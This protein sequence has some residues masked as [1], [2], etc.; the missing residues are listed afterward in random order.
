M[1]FKE[2]LTK[3]ESLLE[4]IS[5]ATNTLLTAPSLDHALTQAMVFLGQATQV[6]RIYVFQNGQIPLTGEPTMSQRWEWVNLGVQSEFDNSE[7][8]NLPYG[9]ELYR[10]YQEM[11]EGKIIFGLIKDFPEA[12]KSILEPQGILSILVVP[13]LIKQR[14]WGFVGFDNCHESHQWTHTEITTLWA[15]AGCFGGA[16]ARAEAESNLQELNQAL[17]LR[18]EERTRELQQATAAANKANHAKSEF[19]ANMSHEL[20]TPLN[21]ILGYAQ[22]LERSKDLSN[23]DLCGIQVIHQ[24]ASHLLDLINDVLDLAKIEAHKLHLVETVVNFSALLQS[25]VDI[26]KI[27]AEQKGID[28]FYQP[29]D[30]L[31]M[32]VRIDAK[33]LKQVLINLLGNAIKFTDKGAVALNINVVKSADSEA[34]LH[35]EIAD[36]GVGI[37]TEDMDRLFESFE[38]VGESHRKEKGTGLGLTISQ[39]V[40]QLMG[41]NIRV[42]SELGVGSKFQ[43]TIKAKIEQ[44][45]IFQPV[46]QIQ[47]SQIIAYTGKRRTILIVDDRW[48]NR[49]VLSKFLEPLGFIIIE[50]NHGKTGL[51]K[52]YKYQPDLLIMD[53]AMPVMDGSTLLKEIKQSSNF[54]KQKVIVSSSSVFHQNQVAAYE[55]GGDAFLPKP[56][57]FSLLL[58]LLTKELDLAWIYEKGKKDDFSNITDNSDPFVETVQA[59]STKDVVVPPTRVLQHLLYLVE[60]GRLPQFKAELEALNSQNQSYKEFTK[61]LF[62][63]DKQ[64]KVDA[65]EASIKAAILNSKMQTSK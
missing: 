45:E 63:L 53:L 42:E 3:L 21:G 52:L 58:S 38:Q 4:G 36:S 25:V 17:E 41:G 24:C 32:G 56:V 55:A 28:F 34:S 11:N 5:L 59:L 26:C 35:F 37:A 49:A 16:I 9:N 22:I 57:D 48:E 60:R 27:N 19:L 47:N 46:V 62:I 30:D 54:N 10:W 65:I 33:R 40:I 44:G 18:I 12:E 13:I 7:L 31:Q 61:P 29:T 20:R 2:Q 64:F 6:D 23:K 39:Q 15:V 8:Q 43:F 50:A 51:E 1:P 14:F